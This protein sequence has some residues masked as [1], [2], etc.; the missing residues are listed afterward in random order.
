[1]MIDA[2]LPPTEVGTSK[3][4]ENP[5]TAVTQLIVIHFVNGM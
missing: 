1:M 4:F 2:Q 5:L 3:G